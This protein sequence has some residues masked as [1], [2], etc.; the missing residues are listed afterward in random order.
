MISYKPFLKM[1]ID[2]DMKKVDILNAGIMSKRT[3]NKMNGNEYISL[4]VI[5]KL[6]NYLKCNITDIIQFIPDNPKDNDWLVKVQIKK[7]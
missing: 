5:D 1:L 2:R 4:E 3:L 6:C 7:V